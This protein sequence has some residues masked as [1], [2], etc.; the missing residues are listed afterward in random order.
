[1][2]ELFEKMKEE[3]MS[4]QKGILLHVC[5]GPC[6]SACIERLISENRSCV[7]FYS[8]SNI[9]SEEEFQRR[10]ECVK[11]LAQYHKL[12]LI[13]DPYDH[14]AWHR[15][16]EKRCPDYALQPEKGGRCRQCFSFSF[17]AAAEKAAALGLN[18]CSSL[19]VSPHKNSRVIFE[20]GSQWTHFEPWDFKKKDGFKRSLLLSSQFGFYRQDFCGCEYSVRKDG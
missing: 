12:E 3:F 1:M 17:H 8:N 20:V 4:A 7:L 14:E 19:T 18:F 11:F 5:C 2:E 15:F 10:L 13:V 16:M 9:I 6:A